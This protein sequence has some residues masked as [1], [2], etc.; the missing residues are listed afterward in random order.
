MTK[1]ELGQKIKENLGWENMEANIWKDG[2]DNYHLEIMPENAT[3]INKENY[4]GR[5]PLS[6][7]YWT[8]AEFDID[9][10]EE[11]LIV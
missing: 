10:L 6:S 2:E 11:S 7:H 4:L 1:K 5:I 9:E 8:D 3:I